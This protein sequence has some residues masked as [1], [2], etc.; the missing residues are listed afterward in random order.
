MKALGALED[1]QPWGTW[2][3]CSITAQPKSRGAAT[4]REASGLKSL[5]RCD[6]DSTTN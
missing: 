2:G 4:L 6:G 5:R 3:R 1:K